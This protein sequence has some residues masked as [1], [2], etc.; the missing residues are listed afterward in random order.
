MPSKKDKTPIL[1]GKI[2]HIYNRGHNYNQVFFKLGDYT[3]FIRLLKKYLLNVSK[4]YAYCLLPNHYHFMIRINEHSQLG[5]FSNQFRKFILAYT[6]IINYRERRSG[7]L[8]LYPFKR[9]EINSKDYFKRLIFYIHFNPQKHNI[10][11]SYKTYAH[12]SF[13]HYLSNHS[14][15]VCTSDVY[16]IFGSRAD[17]L[18]Y[19]DHA[20]G[21]PE[22]DFIP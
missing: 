11:E 7:G 16:E 8:F 15:F 19:H 17:F 13:I 12:C 21:E 1:P 4:V 22:R 10:S 20:S 3:M 18:Q 5:E 2:Y 6:N 9:I 14:S